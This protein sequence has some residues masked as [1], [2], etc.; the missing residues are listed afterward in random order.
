VKVKYYDLRVF[1]SGSDL[2][3]QFQF[4]EHDLF[5]GSFN[6]VNSSAGEKKKIELNVPQQ[7]WQI[8]EEN[9][10]DSNHKLELIFVLKSIGETNGSELSNP[11]IAVITKSDN[12]SSLLLQP[13]NIFTFSVISYSIYQTVRSYTFIRS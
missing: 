11:A 7:I 1:T 10:I 4:T 12:S 3:E 6:S 5:E 13:L 8:G 2:K 9:L